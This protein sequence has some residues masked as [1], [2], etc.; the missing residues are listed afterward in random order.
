[1]IT[2]GD[3]L[4]II[5][6]VLLAALAMLVLVGAAH[7]QGIGAPV[8]WLP[9]QFD[10]ASGVLLPLGKLCSYAAGTTTPLATYLDKDL[11]TQNQNPMI[12]GSDGRPAQPIYLDAASYKFV[13]RTAG[14]NAFCNT[15][16]VVWTYD[17][18][19]DLASF[20]RIAFATKLDD[21]V[22]HASQYTGST[23][24]AKI[25]A[26][27]AVLPST[28]GAIDTRGIQGAQSF[29]ADPFTGISKPLDVWCDG[30]VITI[31]A[32]VTVPV[33]VTWHFG[34]GCYITGAST[35]IFNG[36]ID[37]PHNQKIF[38]TALPLNLSTTSVPD[39]FGAIADNC[40][41]DNS[42]AI[43]AAVR[44][45]YGN[46]NPYSNNIGPSGGGW[47][48]V[49][50]GPGVYCY[51]AGFTVTHS[52]IHLRGMGTSSTILRFHP[53][54]TDIAISF[55]ATTQ[56]NE[57]HDTGIQDMTI[58]AT[59]SSGSVV[60]KALHLHDVSEA[61]FE[62]VYIRDF[63]DA[64]HASQCIEIHGREHILFTDV[65][66]YC[67][68]PLVIGADDNASNEGLDTSYFKH[69]YLGAILTVAEGSVCV[70][71]KPVVDISEA[72]AFLTNV[73]FDDFDFLCGSYSV[74]WSNTNVKAP[75][76]N[77]AFKNGRNEAQAGHPV[78]NWAFYLNVPATMP[79]I[80]LA[81]DNVA[82]HAGDKGGWYVRDVTNGSIN[83]SS[84]QNTASVAAINADATVSM[85]FT[86]VNW[87]LHT[88]NVYNALNGWCGV[89]YGDDA[90]GSNASTGQMTLR[91][92]GVPQVVMD[93]SPGGTTYSITDAACVGA[94]LTFTTST[95]A[96]AAGGQITVSGVSPSGLN[97]TYTLVS[98]SATTATV[99]S[100]SCPL[101][102][103]SGG[104]NAMMYG[105]TSYVGTNSV[106]GASTA[107]D[108]QLRTDGAAI[109]FGSNGT[110]QMQMP[111]STGGILFNAAGVASGG[112]GTVGIGGTVV[113]A[114]ASGC[115][116]TVRKNGADVA[117]AGCWV[118]KVA[119]TTSYAPYFQ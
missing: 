35:L 57:I 117:P 110:M 104:A 55:D 27:I 71:D 54:V 77:V 105:P 10:N 63:S 94:A 82:I 114:G 29:A 12:L 62:G 22:C 97:G 111:A 90:L 43:Q 24:D 88:A 65:I 101:T 118:M 58:D 60:K 112:A 51:T 5:G 30:S 119:G 106:F 116:T 6:T 86:N 23:M 75:S 103:S 7:G 115:P 84:F 96:F 53:S 3:V 93:S 76:Q 107:G 92:C 14:T 16:T 73:T 39:W 95:N 37:N 80:N 44:A 13:L 8:P 50:F 108:L 40:T 67:N 34:Q 1:M 89:H 83:S 28:G 19:Y 100:P 99:I 85:S 2:R 36:R 79:L 41:T 91:S 61:R 69:I 87:N 66:A 11:M 26:C 74:Y 42:A 9:N 68:R 25:A 32:N 38:A 113:A 21:K 49:W 45:F 72:D 15:G 18:V 47:N 17:N 33:N 59:G 52:G 98:A 20:M 46:S 109:D 48:T 70:E 31:N 81:I 102:Y 64:T 78:A 4:Y 56:P